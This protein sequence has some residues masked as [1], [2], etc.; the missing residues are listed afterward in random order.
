MIDLKSPKWLSAISA[1]FPQESWKWEKILD[2]GPYKSDYNGP[3]DLPGGR[4]C[5]LC[6][7]WH[8]YVH[9]IEHPDWPVSY[10]V[11]STCA[12]L[13]AQVDAD[14]LERQFIKEQVAAERAR[15]LALKEQK[16]RDAEEDQKWL[17]AYK[18]QVKREEEEQACRDELERKWSAWSLTKPAY[19]RFIEAL[20]ETWSSDWLPCQNKH[21]FAKMFSAPPRLDASVVLVRPKGSDRYKFVIHCPAGTSL[22]SQR[23]YGS[24]REAG[25]AAYPTFRRIMLD[26]LETRAGFLK[27]S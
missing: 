20:A 26:F 2:A 7:T 25:Y 15:S 9:V 16:Q 17:A 6:H 12:S 21:H 10:M 8:R 11:G 24:A 1:G 13:L 22:F 5:D 14:E 18:A 23:S 3:H 4:Q 27:L 19:Q